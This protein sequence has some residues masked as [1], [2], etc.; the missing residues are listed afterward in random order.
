MRRPLLKITSLFGFFIFGV[1]SPNMQVVDNICALIVENT[2]S[3]GLLVK[4]QESKLRFNH[5]TCCIRTASVS[6]FPMTH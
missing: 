3:R 2:C 4:A 1:N 5:S 6:R